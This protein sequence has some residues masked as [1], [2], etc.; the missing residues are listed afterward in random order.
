MPS[1]DRK[2]TARSAS[3]KFSFA[4]RAV[5]P[6]PGHGKGVPVVTGGGLWTVTVILL[7]SSRGS[8]SGRR[9]REVASRLGPLRSE[10]GQV[11]A[12]PHRETGRS[13]FQERANPL[14]DIGRLA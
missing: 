12:Y 11:S 8:A 2:T 6:A 4:E 14:G 3:F 10:V 9:L 7:S 13:F 5:V 1:S